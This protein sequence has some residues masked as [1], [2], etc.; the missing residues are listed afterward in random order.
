MTSVAEL[1]VSATM[2]QVDNAL[3]ESFDEVFGTG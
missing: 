3:K 2:A 1:G